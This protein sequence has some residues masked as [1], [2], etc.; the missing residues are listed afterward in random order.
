MC[1]IIAVVRRRSSRRPPAAA[2]LTG[3]LDVAADALGG[4][5]WPGL[6]GLERAAKAVAGV[7]AALR[8]VPGVQALV[9]DP[10]LAQMLAE[11]VGGVEARVHAL[12]QALDQGDLR[13]EEGD[14]EAVNAAVV[15]L[16]DACWALLR[17][18]LRNADE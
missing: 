2:D 11:R 1:G 7:D 16:K 18:R 9:G 12:E 8:G 5:G 3:H 13:P 17:D 15:R 10:T 14:V 6:V 4:S